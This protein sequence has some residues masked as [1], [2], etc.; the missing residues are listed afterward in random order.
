MSRPKK[1]VLP[2]D[3]ELDAMAVK[4]HGPVIN[5]WRYRYGYNR[6]EVERYMPT[7]FQALTPAERRGVMALCIAAKEK[8]R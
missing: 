5:K 6:P 4:I 2:T 8:A 1:V 7:S 3:A